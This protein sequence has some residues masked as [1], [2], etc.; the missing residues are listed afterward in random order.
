MCHTRTTDFSGISSISNTLVK[1]I[2]QRVQQRPALAV[3][4]EQINDVKIDIP[5]VPKGRQ[6]KTKISSLSCS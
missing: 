5:A 2:Y 4:K 1:Q 3:P 6:L